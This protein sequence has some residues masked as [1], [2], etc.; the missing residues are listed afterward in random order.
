MWKVINILPGLILYGAALIAIIV[1]I[2][3]VYVFLKPKMEERK[4]R[5]LYQSELE[6]KYK[7]F[8]NDQKK[9]IYREMV[10]INKA[11]A[12]WKKDSNK[13]RDA[14]GQEQKDLLIQ[15]LASRMKIDAKIAEFENKYKVKIIEGYFIYDIGYLHQFI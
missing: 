2:Y 15:V 12:A 6:N 9:I 11:K 4:R 13:A 10:S 5:E 14:R 1:V 8:S 3:N 7:R